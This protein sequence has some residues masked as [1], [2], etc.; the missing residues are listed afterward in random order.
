MSSKL[1]AYGLFFVL[2]FFSNTMSST[3]YTVSSASQFNSL[4]LQPCDVVTWTNGTYSNQNITFNGMGES[5]SPIV[6]KAETPGGVI[7]T[8]SSEMNIWGDYLIVDGF[9]W[10]GGTGTNNHIEFRRSGSN[11]DFANN[12]II[13]NCAF[14][15]LVTAGDDKSRWVVLYGTNNTVENCSFLKCKQLIFSFLHL[16][17]TLACSLLHK[18]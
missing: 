9:Y 4:N 10:N 17:K 3:D 15:S 6:L 7:F 14:N 13:R 16:S 11:T 12:A 1:S 2:F 18:T 8:G 5:G